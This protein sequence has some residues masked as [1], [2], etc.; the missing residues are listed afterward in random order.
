MTYRSLRA[1]SSLL[2]LLSISAFA[3]DVKLVAIRVV[4]S[5]EFTEA[6]VSRASGLKVNQVIGPA[7]FKNAADRLAG[8]G[9]FASVGYKYGPLGNGMFVEFDVEDAPSFLPVRFENF[10]WFTDAELNA[11]LKER[12]PLYHGRLPEGGQIVDDVTAALT[13]VLA[14]RG[15]NGRTN[16]RLYSP[17]MGKPIEAISFV[18]E[19]PKLAVHNIEFTGESQ[20]AVS[21]LKQAVSTVIGSPYERG[22]IEETIFFRLQPLYLNKGFLKASI[23]QPATALSGSA[24]DPDV[25][26]TVVV[27]E[28]LQYKLGEIRWSGMTLMNSGELAK[29]I[30]CTAGKPLNLPLLLNGL[31]QDAEAYGAKGYLETKFNLKP[32]YDDNRQ[33]V[34]YEVAVVEGR[35]FKMG[36]FEVSGVDAK[37]AERISKSWKLKP[38]DPFESRYEDQFVKDNAMLMHGRPAKISRKLNS[39]ATVDV[40]IEL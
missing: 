25:N 13:A 29:P 7:E 18:A 19:G 5:Q 38:G 37:D 3:A 14:E 21:E 28:G 30:K 11:S 16:M 10:V 4:G 8:T 39:D 26:V 32:A 9:A 12:V 31:R 24:S 27:H 6:E 1:L 20:V 33:V 17:G 40:K 2:L 23:E 22:S 36:H 35:Q 15:I 34:D